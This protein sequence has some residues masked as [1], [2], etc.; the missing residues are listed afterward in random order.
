MRNDDMGGEDERGFFAEGP[1]KPPAETTEPAIDK[2]HYHGHRERLR[3]RF[4][5]AGSDALSDYELL[6]LFLFRSIPRADTKGPAKALLKRFGSLAG[7]IG[8]PSQR[9]CEEPGIGEA[10]ARDLKLAGALARRMLKS[11]FMGRQ[12][13]ASWSKVIDYCHAAMA[14]EPREQF[15]I[16][17]LDKKN[18]LIADEVQQTGTV[19]H[20]PVYPREIVRRALELSASAVI[21]VHNHPSGDPTPSQ[22][23]IQMTKTVVETAEPLGITVHDHIIIGASGH[24]SFR[25]THLI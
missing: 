21:L 16:L 5:E 20:T 4:A 23:D 9:L 11:E 22:A 6:E 8:A 1:I 12:V 19:D 14:Y 25:G 3:Q 10:A 2:P 17:F 7:V 18:R 24:V 15:R 13:L